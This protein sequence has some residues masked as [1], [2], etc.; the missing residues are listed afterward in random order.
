MK[1]SSVN[2]EYY[3]EYE[4]RHFLAKKTGNLEQESFKMNL[5]YNQL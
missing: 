2:K 4:D 3:M 1:T 5:I